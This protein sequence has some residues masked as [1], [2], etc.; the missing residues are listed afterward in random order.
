M[1]NLPPPT[2]L[3]S[4]ETDGRGDGQS[5]GLEGELPFMLGSGATLA[6]MNGN[7]G[8]EMLTLER[9]LLRDV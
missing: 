6:P 8:R 3:L 5:S 2:E 9:G 1:H 4:V 7:G